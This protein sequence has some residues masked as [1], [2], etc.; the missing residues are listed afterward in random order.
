[1]LTFTLSSAIPRSPM[2]RRSMG[3]ALAASLTCLAVLSGCSAAPNEGPNGQPTATVDEK[4]AYE[5][6][7]SIDEKVGESTVKVDKEADESMAK[8]VDPAAYGPLVTWAAASG[9]YQCSYGPTGACCSGS[10]GCFCCSTTGH[11]DYCQ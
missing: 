11:C 2:T 5:P 8:L 4:V 7:A 6:T 1:M 10:G 3:L 9:K